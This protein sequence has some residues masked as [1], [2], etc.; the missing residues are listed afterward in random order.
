MS[1][2]QTPLPKNGFKTISDYNK[3][4]DEVLLTGDPQ[5]LSDFLYETRASR[6]S[7]LEVAELIMH[8][9]IT[10]VVTLPMPYRA[11]SKNWLLER[12]YRSWDDGDIPMLKKD[13][14][15]E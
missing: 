6:P 15:T 9:C 11:Q 14:P 7:S 5:R 2:M 4:R 13:N 8:R 3:A 10:A 12:G 1:S